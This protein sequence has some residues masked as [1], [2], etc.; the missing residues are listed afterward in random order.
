MI[1]SVPRRLL[2]LL[3]VTDTVHLVSKKCYSEVSPT[4]PHPNPPYHTFPYHNRPY[5]TKPYPTYPTITQ[6][7]RCAC[8]PPSP[9]PTSLP[10]APAR[11]TDC[12]P[13]PTPSP[14]HRPPWWAGSR[15]L[16]PKFHFQV[17]SCYMTLS[18]TVERYI[19]VVHPLLRSVVALIFTWLIY[20]HINLV[21][22][23]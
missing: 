14:W 6:P 11:T 10:P 7:P 23:S 19:S 17:M 4:I 22:S 1:L 9:C 21:F 5:N 2:L 3:A 13:S 8:S 12:T 15:G 18:L 20:F 16:E